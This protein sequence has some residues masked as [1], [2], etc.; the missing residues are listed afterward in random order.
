ME[1]VALVFGLLFA[2]C[3]YVLGKKEKE[4]DEVSSVEKQKKTLDDLRNRSRHDA[5]S[6][7]LKYRD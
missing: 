4:L 2:F 6:V 1:K 5:D 7:P 3:A